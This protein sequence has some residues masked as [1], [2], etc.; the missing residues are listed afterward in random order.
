MALTLGVKYSRYMHISFVYT[1]GDPRLATFVIGYPI[2]LIYIDQSDTHTW[3]AYN[4][5][6]SYNA[7]CLERYL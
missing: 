2:D 4:T 3:W 7:S 5:M 1:T 6:Y